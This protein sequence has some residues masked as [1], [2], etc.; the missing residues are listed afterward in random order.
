VF[1]EEVNSCAEQDEY[2][3]ERAHIPERQAH[4]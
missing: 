4:T 2:Y 1:N 3:A